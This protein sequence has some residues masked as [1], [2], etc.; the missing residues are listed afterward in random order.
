MILRLKLSSLYFLSL[1][2]SLSLFYSL[3]LEAKIFPKKFN[4]EYS[5]Y[6]EENFIGQVLVDFRQKNN[7]YRIKALTKV[8]GIMK[9][10]GNREI[11]SKG[12]ISSNGFKPEI[13]NLKNKKRP[14]KNV[15][16]VFDYQKKEVQINYKDKN[17]KHLLTNKNLDLITYLYQFNFESLNKKNYIFKVIDGKHNRIYLYNKIR[18]DSIATDIGILEA[19]VYEGKIKEKKNSEHYLWM[20]REP[21]RI[22]LKIEIKT[23]IGININQILL[24]TN[25]IL[26]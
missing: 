15:L 11:S 7:Q 26:N 1:F 3:N 18:Q 21:Y 13:F 17:F 9:L 6:Y 4:S 2:L 25:L 10:V 14:K 12:Q 5:L 8:D 24:K 23:D 20:L 19:D 16:A 22:P